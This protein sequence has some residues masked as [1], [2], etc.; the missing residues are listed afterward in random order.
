MNLP[1]PR[2]LAGL[3]VL[4][5]SSMMAGPYCG[6]WLADLGADVIKIESPEGDYMRTR[7]PLRSG[8][9]AY[10]GHLNC[11]KRSMVLDLKKPAAVGLVRS[12]ASKSD[13]LLE[14]FRPGVMDRFG[15]DYESLR[16]E[17]PALI[18]CSISGYGQEGPMAGNPAYAAIVHATSGFDE[19]WRVSQ[20]GD[21][22]PPTCGVQIADVVAASFATMAVQT[23]LLAR[24]KSGA[25]QRVDLSLMEGMLALM[26]LDIVQAQFPADNRRT[27]YRPVK[28]RDG[29]VVITP[30][31]QKNFTD[32]CTA[33]GREDFKA[34]PRFAS[35]LARVENWETLLGEVQAWAGHRT[36]DECMS[37]LSAA[38][39][40]AARHSSVKQTLESEQLGARGFWAAARDGGGNFL[41][42]RLPF[43]LSA[44][45]GRDPGPALVP[46]LGEH[47]REVLRDILALDKAEIDLLVSQGVAYGV[48]KETCA[49]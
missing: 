38:G 12:L 35:P 29:Y 45:A 43:T 26:P 37:Y 42:A 30:I 21:A 28:A 6:R 4:D 18:Y 16:A 46:E 7:P 11:G 24:Q 36:V 1:A 9:S 25:G 3:R 19:A 33:M 32:L 2:P 34:D 39:V 17:N 40:P 15:L 44:D 47:T 14:G 41:A 5:L 10:F 31:S 23:A 20:P 48:G 49:A 8:Y 27:S 22:L 13:V